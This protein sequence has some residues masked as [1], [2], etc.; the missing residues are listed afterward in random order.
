MIG[1]KVNIVN[2][3]NESLLLSKTRIAMYIKNIETSSEKNIEEDGSIVKSISFFLKNSVGS[4]IIKTES[5]NNSKC[6]TNS[7][8]P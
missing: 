8:I 7:V 2:M 5:K 6:H 4:R 3:I 1:L